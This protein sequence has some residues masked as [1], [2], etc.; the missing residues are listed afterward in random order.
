MCGN[1]IPLKK[2]KKKRHCCS[3]AP[4]SQELFSGGYC[5]IFFPPLVESEPDSAVCKHLALSQKRLILR[6][7]HTVEI[8]GLKRTCFSLN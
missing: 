4:E 7:L 3:V 8:V 5:W 1:N 2:K 6:I